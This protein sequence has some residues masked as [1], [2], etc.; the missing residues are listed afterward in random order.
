MPIFLRWCIMYIIYIFR[1]IVL[2]FFA[3]FITTFRPLFAPAFFSWLEFRSVQRPKHCDKHGDKDEDNSPKNVNKIKL[4]AFV[5]VC[6][7]VHS[8]LRSVWQQDNASRVFQCEEIKVSYLLYVHINILISAIILNCF[9]FLLSY[10][11]LRLWFL[12]S[13]RWNTNI[14]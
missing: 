12:H 3:M 8:R 2:I 6:L 10:I 11:I 13:V 4:C 1:T 9:F 5:C 7:W 14:F